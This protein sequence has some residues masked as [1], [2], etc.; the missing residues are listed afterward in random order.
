MNITEIYDVTNAESEHF[1]SP[2]ER[3]A[4]SQL[5][6]DNDWDDDQINICDDGTSIIVQIPKNYLIE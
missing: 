2:F 1:Q 6:F 4:N 5:E 3:D